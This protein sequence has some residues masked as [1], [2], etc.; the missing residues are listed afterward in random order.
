[1]EEMDCQS[2]RGVIADRLG[3]G[4]AHCVVRSDPQAATR[5]RPRQEHHR[6]QGDAKLDWNV[7]PSASFLLTALIANSIST[8]GTAPTVD[9]H[10]GSSNENW[11]LSSD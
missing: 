1:V 7:P 8:V 6:E 9:Q 5:K 3:P 10:L 2:G 4:H 11:R